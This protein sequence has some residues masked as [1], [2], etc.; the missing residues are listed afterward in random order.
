MLF[1]S[2]TGETFSD[3]LTGC[4]MKKAAEYL[5]GTNYKTYEISLMVGYDNPKNFT[6]AFK[7]YYHV[8]PREFRDNR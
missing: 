8:T 3:Y 7:Q 4:R 6:R 5:H 1:R 2:V